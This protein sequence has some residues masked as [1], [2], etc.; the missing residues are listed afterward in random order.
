MVEDTRSATRPKVYSIAAHRG[1]ADALVAGLVPR[2][3]D[4][5]VGLAR[6]TLLLPSSRARRTLSEAF[7]R[8]MGE[9]DAAGLLLPRM[10]VVGDLDLD[11]ALGPLLDPLGAGDILPAIDSQRRQFALAQLLADEMGDT[12]PRGATLLRL[13]RETGDTMDRLLIEDIGPEQLLDEAV[14]GV[15]PD[16]A[17]HWQES[18]RLFARVQLR[19]LEWLNAQGRIDTAARRNRLFEKASR[20]W[21]AR[22]P[23][24]PIVAAGINSAAPTLARLLRVVSELPDGAVVLPDFDLTMD[25]QVWDELGRAGAAPQP[26]DTG[27]ARED[28]VTHPQY[29]LKLLL[30]RMGV[31]REEVQPWHRKG[32]TAAPPTRS[33]AISA[34]FLPPEASKVWIDLP[35]EKRRLSGVRIMEA[36]NPEEE[37]QAIA[38][39][40]RQALEEPGRRVAVVTPD[41]P[42]ARR[43]VHHLDRWNITADD[44]AGRPLSQ[45]AAGRAF[46]LAAEVMAQGARSVPLVALLGHPLADGGMDRGRWLR[47]LRLLERALRGPRL[48]PGLQPVQ[49]IVAD[50][51]DKQPDMA[52]WWA[53][54]LTHLHP[55]DI[56]PREDPQDLA[57]LIDV[58]AASAEGLCGEKLWAREDGRS[59]AGFVENFRQ[60]ARDTGYRTAPQDV[61][62]VLTDAM[63][64]CAVR[65]P[66]GG[67]ARVQVL[68]LL[69][70]RMNR[71]DLVICAG[72]NEGVWP[73]RGTVDALLAPP[74]LRS[75]GVAGSEFRIGLSAHDLAGALGAPEVVLSRSERDE[76]GPAI[77]SRF[78]LRVQALLGELLPRHVDHETIALARAMT[79]APRALDYPRPAPV[80]TVEQRD[81]DI[82]ATALDRLLGDP[83]QFYAQKIMGLSDLD[84]L[85]AEP[86]AL[87][88]GNIAH[89]ILERWHLARTTDP[90]ARIL[91]IMDA[92]LDEANADP[93]IRG[94]W[95][96]RLQCALEWVEDTVGAYTDRDVLA[97]EAHGAIHVDGLRVH[98]RADRIDRLDDGSLAIVDYKSGKPPSAAQVEQGFA[99]QLGILGLIAQDGGFEGLSGQPSAYE[100]WSLGRSRDDNPH[101][102]GYVEVP[103]KTGNRR[104]GVEPDDFLPLTRGKLALAIGKYIRGNAPFTARENPD[105]PAYDTYDQLMRL[106]EWLPRQAD[107][108]EDGVAT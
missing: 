56:Q 96:P 104:S 47:R 7:V 97:V 98:G 77:A 87:W 105:Y 24:T 103:L 71:A 94:L 29:H 14:V 42:L 58:L 28:A 61:A 106:E 8:L 2:Y 92:V 54:A 20:T 34:L 91:P 12:A 48:A 99:L 70:A 52:D 21:S 62:A 9:G 78:L 44:S 81:V 68:G 82:S 23:E 83:Y 38:L 76:S 79:R 39:L 75:L 37:A 25:A 72:L 80:P 90:A 93:L 3:R 55:L 69:E 107:A 102:F 67:H 10:V 64:C 95:Q 11:E 32:M 57:G 15:V 88:Q 33:H 18:I 36:A 22:P 27:F 4:E 50:L 101:G 63:E 53:L 43:V 100:Y 19:W 31:A 89:E 26:G 65:P 5:A 84:A 51:A 49:D 40:V 86:T 85:D 1:F 13:A 30:N 60:H 59:L 108:Q 17:G 16:L 6:L 46:L 41:R 35:S 45:T 74:V 73:A 66:Y